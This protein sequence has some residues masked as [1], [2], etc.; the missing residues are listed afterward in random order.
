MASLRYLHL[1]PALRYPAFRT[2]WLG[3][4][5]SI[6]STQ[7]RILAA[8]WLVY[9]LKESELFLGYAGL[10]S[11][12]PSIILTPFG[13]V[14][15]DKVDKRLLL[16]VASVLNTTLMILLATLTLFEAI[17]VWHVLMVSFV[18]GIIWA[19]QGPAHEAF[20]PQPG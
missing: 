1:P 15:A 9:D 19:V 4:L 10:A 2:F 12:I 3:S 20:I 18:G 8:G 5:A 13:G 14:I 16:G 17:D 11:A 7:I 6:G